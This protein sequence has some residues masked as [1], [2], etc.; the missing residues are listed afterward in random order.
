MIRRIVAKLNL[1]IC[2]LAVIFV[3]TIWARSWFHIDAALC[4]TYHRRIDADLGSVIWDTNE[5]SIHTT[6]AGGGGISVNLKWLTLFGRAGV[7]A[8]HAN[9]LMEGTHFYIGVPDFV[10]QSHDT[11]MGQ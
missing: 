7:F 5:F 2:L 3:G 11:M 8:D 4:T 9:R 1:I 10:Q 6:R